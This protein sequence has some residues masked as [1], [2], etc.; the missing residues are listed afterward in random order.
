VFRTLVVDAKALHA[1]LDAERLRLEA[2]TIA[3]GQT[4]TYRQ[5]PTPV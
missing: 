1:F 2:S 3:L 5:A 4:V